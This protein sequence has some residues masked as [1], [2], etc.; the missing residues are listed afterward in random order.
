M[1][2]H[3]APA[4]KVKLVGRSRAG[5]KPVHG[6]PEQ[7]GAEADTALPGAPAAHIRE[8]RGSRKWYTTELPACMSDAVATMT[9]DATQALETCRRTSLRRVATG[10]WA[11][12]WSGLFRRLA[13][14]PL[15]LPQPRPSL[16]PPTG[17]CP[18]YPYG[19]PGNTKPSMSV[20]LVLM[21]LFTF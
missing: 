4:A 13:R 12:S 5:S 7:P 6:Q 20:P 21:L 1:A 19:A 9:S 11:A 17:S 18:R 8:V 15:P 3:R 2:Q 14:P 16:P 10:S